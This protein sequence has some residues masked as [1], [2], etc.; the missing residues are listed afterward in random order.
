MQVQAARN[1]GKTLTA[2]TDLASV[3][4]WDGN[5]FGQYTPSDYPAEE[6]WVAQIVALS[7]ASVITFD[8]NGNA[9]IGWP[10]GLEQSRHAAFLKLLDALDKPDSNERKRATADVIKLGPAAVAWANEA[11]GSNSTTP[12]QAGSLRY[13]KQALEEATASLEKHEINGVHFGGRY[14]V[15]KLAFISRSL[16]G[17][18][19]LAADECFDD[20]GEQFLGKC[21]LTIETNG[22]W[23]ASLIDEGSVDM[24]S[25]GWPEDH[26]RDIDHTLF[27]KTKI[28]DVGHEV[29]QRSNKPFALN[30]WH[31]LGGDGE[32]TGR[33]Y[34][35]S[36]DGI[37]LCNINLTTTTF[38]ANL[39]PRILSARALTFAAGER[40]AWALADIP[41]RILSNGA[42][43]PITLPNDR[44]RA[45]A[46]SALQGN[47]AIIWLK[48]NDPN[49][50]D[51]AL[52]A[53]LYNDNHWIGVPGIGS[54]DLV[55]ANATDIPRV[56][57]RDFLAR[58]T[59]TNANVPTFGSDRGI[60][61]WCLSTNSHWIANVNKT[62]WSV[63][64]ECYFDY[65]DSN[66]WNN[67]WDLF[68][69]ETKEFSSQ[70]LDTE[71]E[72]VNPNAPP[73]PVKTHLD[74]FL[75]LA[76]VDDGHVAL[77]YD[78]LHKQIWAVSFE[79]GRLQKKVLSGSE[80]L[81]GMPQTTQA[82]KHTWLVNDNKVGPSVWKCG[83]GKLTP[84]NV[85][86]SVV[87][88]QESGR[89]W[90][91]DGK[92]L[93][94][95]DDH[96]T[97]S[98]NIESLD[99]NGRII[100]GNHD[101]VWLMTTEGLFQIMRSGNSPS[102]SSRLINKWNT[103]VNA[104]SGFIDDANGFWIPGDGDQIVRLQLPSQQ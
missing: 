77:V 64:P 34:Y 65:F 71:V 80:S 16:D 24:P 53:Y 33:V 28:F 84:I 56:A 35:S 69:I 41:L 37:Y 39:S 46:I 54:S 98:V 101:D 86:G 90:V 66:A 99:Q 22:Q 7:D 72:P 42:T 17:R 59:A 4:L 25:S 62:Q 1:A 29:T 96:S 43:N 38:P 40:T 88:A 87:A 55:H 36:N 49:D 48:S 30:I 70:P 103:P 21:L 2:R 6:R 83:D 58:G 61:L 19:R 92:K 76:T 73:T 81:I 94:A 104:L 68:P 51:Q 91:R 45:T 13:I 93:I 74:Y 75:V 50:A 5:E 102:L 11:L 63:Q 47:A 52:T 3:I 15:A 95:I 31:V 97:A 82:G 18:V 79:D 23:H 14:K 57:P 44:M 32:K 26:Y 10:T 78:R 100:F 89:L 60:G 20:L 9:N 85:K 12:E 27:V 67:V 8:E